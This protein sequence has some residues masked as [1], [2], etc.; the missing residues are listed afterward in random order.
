MI[1][2]YNGEKY[3][4]KCLASVLNQTYIHLQIIVVDDGSLDHSIEVCQRIAATGHRIQVIHTENHGVSHA[5]NTGLS[6]AT[7]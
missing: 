3:I 5:R 7:G 2:V 1:P 4:E 6:V